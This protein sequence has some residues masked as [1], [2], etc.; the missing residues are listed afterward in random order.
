MAA[1]AA[2]PLAD[3][4][5]AHV[6]RFVEDG[7]TLQTG[8]GRIPDAVLRE[9]TAR[10]G[11]RIHSGLIGDGVLALM[12][13]GALARDSPI[14]AGVAIG[15]P[16]FY[17][18]IGSKHFEFR[19]VSYTHSAEI[20]ARIPGLVT[21]NSAFEVDLFGQAYAELG[22]EG[23]T[24]GPGG[25]SDFARGARAGGGLRIVVLASGA[26][27]GATSRVVAPGD[28]KGPVSLGRMDIDVIATEHGAADLRG[29][30]HSA[31]ARAI[32]AIAPVWHRD[33]LAESWRSIAARF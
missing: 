25:A 27:R 8:L 15:S 10:R 13:A 29:L 1:T 7:M 24:S 16:E 2:D 32:I 12:T 14:V 19:P 21:I 23:L 30:D 20:L 31:R 22:P 6:A 28:A 26:A 9:L 11:L 4:I 18:V 17:A 33:H 3:A 5:G